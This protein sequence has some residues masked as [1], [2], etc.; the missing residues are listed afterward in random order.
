VELGGTHE[1]SGRPGLAHAPY[2][3]VRLEAAASDGS[4][5]T[6]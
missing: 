2:E 1:S 4:D 5:V 3:P 6:R